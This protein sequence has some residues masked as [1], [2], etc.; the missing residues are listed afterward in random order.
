MTLVSREEIPICPGAQHGCGRRADPAIKGMDGKFRCILCNELHI[1]L[2]YME[3]A[4]SAPNSPNAVVAAQMDRQVEA[5]RAELAK[6][7]SDP[8]KFDEAVRRAREQPV[9]QDQDLKRL[10]KLR[11]DARER[12]ARVRESRNRRDSLL[13]KYGIRT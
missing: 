7:L 5:A 9:R 1:E 8:R 4:T 2:A 11:A 12:E 3:S 13:R 6:Q 10:L